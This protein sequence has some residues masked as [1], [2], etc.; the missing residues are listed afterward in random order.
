MPLVL[1]GFRHILCLTPQQILFLRGVLSDMRDYDY[2]FVF[3]GILGVLGSL[4]VILTHVLLPS[5]RTHSRKLLVWLSVCDLGQGLFFSVYLGDW[6]QDPTVCLVHHMFG[7]FT[8]AGSFWWTSCIASYVFFTLYAP[9]RKCE[10]YTWLFHVVSWGYPIAVLI[11]YRFYE[12]RYQY[13]QVCYCGCVGVWVY[14][15]RGAHRCANA[16]NPV[17]ILLST[18]KN[19]STCTRRVCTQTST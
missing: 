9:Q 15:V 7:V 16:I 14:Y 5:M 18:T 17:Q 2:L 3:S 6:L 11:P 19:Q 10:S 4:V 1:F 12:I 13:P 8:A